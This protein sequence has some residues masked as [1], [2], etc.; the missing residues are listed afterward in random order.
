M[1]EHRRTAIL[2][3]FFWHFFF[4]F[5]QELDRLERN[6]TVCPLP[7]PCEN[8]KE[9]KNVQGTHKLFFY[10]RRGIWTCPCENLVSS[11]PKQGASQ[12]A[13]LWCWKGASLGQTPRAWLPGAA[14]WNVLFDLP[15]KTPVVLWEGPKPFWEGNTTEALVQAIWHCS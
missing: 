11:G 2:H 8:W 4:F 10:R 13:Q 14:G 1:R 9:T 6:V 15:A 5:T 3:V 7:N 12:P